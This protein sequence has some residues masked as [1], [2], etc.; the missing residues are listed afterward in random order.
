M[1]DVLIVE[2]ALPFQRWL[3]RTIPLL[4]GDSETW[5]VGSAADAEGVLADATPEVFLLDLSIPSREG[6]AMPSPDHGLS[7]LERC[8]VRYPK[9][10]II[11]L[12]SHSDLRGACLSAGADHFVGKDDADLIGKLRSA[13]G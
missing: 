5:V 9:A 7:L 2:D 12:S 8:R 1:A 13:L 6:D 3:T 10:R 11:V 4:L